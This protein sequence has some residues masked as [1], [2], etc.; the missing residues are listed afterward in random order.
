MSVNYNFPNEVA[1]SILQTIM[2]WKESPNVSLRLTIS[3]PLPR[4]TALKLMSVTAAEHSK[5]KPFVDSS[6]KLKAKISRNL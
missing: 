3:M 5:H 2:N 6:S 1:E 4:L